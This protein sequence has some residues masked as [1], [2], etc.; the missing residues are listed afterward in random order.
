MA[1]QANI[2]TNIYYDVNKT[3]DEDTWVNDFVD[4]VGTNLNIHYIENFN[5]GNT[6]IGKWV[7][8]EWN[9]TSGIYAERELITIKDMIYDWLHA[10]QLHLSNYYVTEALARLKAKNYL[11][12][13]KF[14]IFDP[15]DPAINC[16]NGIWYPARKTLEPHSPK[17]KFLNQM[18]CDF[19]YYP[20][21]NPNKKLRDQENF[22]ILLELEKQMPC[23]LS[24]RKYYPFEMD[25]IE[26]YVQMII[27]QDIIHK[28]ILFIVG[29]SN[30][31]KSTVA[32]ILTDIFSTVA[33]YQSLVELNEKWGLMSLIGKRV[34]FDLDSGVGRM[35]GI[36]LGR[37]KAIVGDPGKKLAVPIIYKGVQE[38]VLSPF[39]LTFSN[40]LQ[41]L[42]TNIDREAWGKRALCLVM[43]HTFVDDENFEQNI[44]KERNALFTYLCLKPYHP[45]TREE[46]GGFDKFVKR[47]LDIWDIW[48]HPIRKIIFESFKRSYEID[49]VYR[50]EDVEN[51]MYEMMENNNIE[52]NYNVEKIIKKIFKRMGISEAV[53]TVN[54]EKVKC[55][56]GVK[57]RGVPEGVSR[58]PPYDRINIFTEPVINNSIKQKI[59]KITLDNIKIPKVSKTPEKIEQP[60]PISWNDRKNIIFAQIL[61]LANEYPRERIEFGD[62][63]EVLAGKV[64]KKE[65]RIFVQRM[66]QSGFMEWKKD[67]NGREGFVYIGRLE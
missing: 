43:D 41:K 35:N 17:I 19:L 24:M 30:T 5:G 50:I 27:N 45:I 61:G 52:P 63:W 25:L 18:D 64:T 2:N 6:I 65:I 48:S 55:Y 58:I 28:M 36:G 37:L 20:S 54:G 23:W 60:H 9:F 34:N 42:P 1:N 53:R 44:L 40:Q 49:A 62:L 31:G 15:Q 38:H 12:I 56:V 59:E 11:S 13:D 47:N 22:E 16:L 32:H 57:L 8:Y 3:L 21:T 7:E 66:I 46:F 29:G 51:F 26:R 14:D 10:N 67:K 4:W 39:F 33:S